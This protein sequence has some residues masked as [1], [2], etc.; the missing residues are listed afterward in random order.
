MWLMI[1]IMQMQ[2]CMYNAYEE[3]EKENNNSHVRNKIR[4]VY[5]KFAEGI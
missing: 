5:L 3:F 1:V 2:K 4:H